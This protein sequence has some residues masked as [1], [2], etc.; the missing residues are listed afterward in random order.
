MISQRP[1]QLIDNLDVEAE[2]RPGYHVHSLAWA[3]VMIA[4]GSHDMYFWTLLWLIGSITKPR[5]S[6]D[7]LPTIHPLSIR[8]PTTGLCIESQQVDHFLNRK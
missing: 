7:I 3:N 5:S 6:F 2:G 1:I 8:H 4:A